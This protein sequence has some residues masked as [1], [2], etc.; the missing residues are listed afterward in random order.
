MLGAARVPERAGDYTGFV[1]AIRLRAVAPGTAIVVKVP[2][3]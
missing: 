1:D 2:L 3:E